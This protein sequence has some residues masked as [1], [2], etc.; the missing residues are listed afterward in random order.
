MIERVAA[1]LAP[2]AF[3]PQ[4]DLSRMNA[5]SAERARIRA[6]A[7]AR[8]VIAEMRDPTGA[9]IDAG[10]SSDAFSRIVCDPQPEVIGWRAMVDAALAG[11]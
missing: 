2:A 1:I 7:R 9:M 11:R 5:S 8:R 10:K 4:S 3:D 6:L